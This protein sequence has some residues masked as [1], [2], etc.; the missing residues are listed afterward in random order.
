MTK[1]VTGLCAT[2]Y[3]W[4]GQCEKRKKRKTRERK[5]ERKN[6]KHYCNL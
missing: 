5:K 4:N 1:P 6:K 2:L 3:L